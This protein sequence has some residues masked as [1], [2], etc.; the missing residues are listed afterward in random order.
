MQ[1]RV[2]DNILSS[3]TGVP[4]SNGGSNDS[5]AAREN[6]T[7]LFEAGEPSYLGFTTAQINGI[8][9]S[10]IGIWR[11]MSFIFDIVRPGFLLCSWLVEA[12]TPLKPHVEEAMNTLQLSLGV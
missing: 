6:A 4:L 1:S 8:W 3:Y 10:P 7:E 2:Y 12:H 11:V 5:E 9:A